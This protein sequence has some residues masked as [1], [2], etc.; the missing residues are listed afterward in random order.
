MISVRGINK[1]FGRFRV[2]K[3]VSLDC[4]PGSCIA[5]VGPNGSGKTT[6]MKTI[7]GMVI[8]DSGTVEVNGRNIAKDWKYRSGIGYMPQITKYP[9]NM[10]VGQIMDMMG[11][12]RKNENR[13]DEELIDSYHLRDIYNKRMSTLS[14]GTRQKVGACLAMLFDPGILILDEPTAGL[15]P[16][17]S[18][19]LKEKL[20][21]ENKKGKVSV[22]STH[23]LTDLDDLVT[24]VVFMQEGKV[25]F[26]KKLQQLMEETGE[27][28][29]SKM[30][31]KV[32][33]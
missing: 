20:I 1:K 11:D 2:L 13:L 3:D 32:L 16:L 8:P 17:S 4:E 14:G 5:L 12:I 25:V 10:T 15:D 33:S 26:Q 7:L 9:D 23:I 28:K 27:S 30:I 24:E 6:L 22:I 31:L 19:I 21:K 18:E 29:I